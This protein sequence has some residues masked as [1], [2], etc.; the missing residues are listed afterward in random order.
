[1]VKAIGCFVFFVGMVLYT[2]ERDKIW[3]LAALGVALFY[4]APWIV[5]KMRASA[6]AARWQRESEARQVAGANAAEYEHQVALRRERERMEMHAEIRVKEL[7]ATLE[8][9]FRADSRKMEQLAQMKADFANRQK[10][11]MAGLLG[12]LEAMRGSR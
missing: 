3:P 7:L 12:Q 11:D 6:S 10:S 2:N 8:V 4:V 5:G 9:Q 1:M